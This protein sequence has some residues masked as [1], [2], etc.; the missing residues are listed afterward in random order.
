MK[1]AREELKKGLTFRAI[2]VAMIIA[3]LYTVPLIWWM[4]YS[5]ARFAVRRLSPMA[6]HLM[7]LTFIIAII[8]LV[9]RRALSKAFSSQELTVIYAILAATL[10]IPWSLGIVTYSWILNPLRVGDYPGVWEAVPDFWLPKSLGVDVLWTGG[11]GLSEF[12]AVALLWSAVTAVLYVFSYSIGLLLRKPFLE[13]EKLPYPLVTPASFLIEKATTAE[14]KG[15]PAI[16]KSKLFWAALII[17]W[18]VN[19][20]YS[21]TGGGGQGSGLELLLG[22]PSPEPYMAY[23]YLSG[24]LPSPFTNIVMAWDFDALGIGLYLLF[25]LDILLTGIIFHVLCYI[26]WPIIQVSTG[27]VKP[28][29]GA[30]EWGAY[31]IVNSTEAFIPESF[32]DVGAYI[33]IGLL[34]LWVVRKPLM[35]SVRHAI[36][37]TG[38]EKPFSYRT[39][40]SL[41]IV[42]A[43]IL[44]GFLAAS[45][46]DI[47]SSIVTIVLLAFA[48]F[49]LARVR[50]EVWP[51][52]SNAWCCIQVQNS[53][54]N[55]LNPVPVVQMV[56]GAPTGVPVGTDVAR[57]IYVTSGFLNVTSYYGVWTP[58]IASLESLKLAEE[59]GT[60]YRDVVIVAVPV[61]IVVTFLTFIFLSM[62][63]TQFGART[64]LS[65]WWTGWQFD[66]IGNQDAANAL[67]SGIAL[68]TMGRTI[69][70]VLG[71]LVAIGLG[72]AR[73]TVAG[74][75]LN[76]LGMI[77]FSN[78]FYGFGYG[79]VAYIIKLLVLKIAG[80]KT[81]E[82]KGL[83]IAI[84]LFLGGYIGFYPTRSVVCF[85]LGR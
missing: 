67:R 49:I 8:A 36:K 40:W 52:Y 75:P 79:L 82:E 73:I 66:R 59:T 1:V 22:Y 43:I 3:L 14:E 53:I 60:D 50:G 30:G 24:K 54:T 12:I 47:L 84:G 11:I 42:T 35:E 46:A 55:P 33:G 41:I 19:F 76:P 38:D 15:L 7:F 81:W 37:G 4:R 5:S 20:Y 39:I 68:P 48:I 45:G 64:F 62:N 9:T 51:G 70:T 69:W 29:P 83:P 18:L 65:D 58:A 85:L 26:I 61:A 10:P 57:S 17:G 78:S 27:M 63:V 32:L 44:I 6:M 16:L 25:P 77:L 28:Q 23:T 71:A 31:G 34:G 21:P 72:L 56:S 80:A 74:F 2:A 13:V